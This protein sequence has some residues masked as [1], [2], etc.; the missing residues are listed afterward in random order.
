MKTSGCSKHKGAPRYCNNDPYV[1]RI[2]RE[3]DGAF[4]R[5]ISQYKGLRGSIFF[6]GMY[7]NSA[8]VP[9]GAECGPRPTA[10]GV[11][12]G[13]GSLLAVPRRREKRP[14]Q[15]ALSVAT[16]DHMIINNGSQYNQK[17]HPSALAVE[18]GLSALAD[19][20]RTF[21]MR[22]AYP[23]SVNVVSADTLRAAQK[24]PDAYR[25]SWCAWRLYGVFS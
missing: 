6:A 10:Q 2:A 7:S 8:N 15:A 16:L 9:I 11:C 17:Y 13:R 12:A 21:S 18:K 3:V 1:D 14:T 5:I 20:I 25:I 22:A 19:L 4:S 24:N 23:H